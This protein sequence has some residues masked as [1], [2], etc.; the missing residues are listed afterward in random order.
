MIATVP[1]DE[2]QPVLAHNQPDWRRLVEVLT[3]GF[4]GSVMVTLWGWGSPQGGVPTHVRPVGV[5]VAV[6]GIAGLI[7][8]IIAWLRSRKLV[9]RRVL[10]LVVW[11]LPLLFSPPLLSQDGWA[12]AAQGL[13]LIHI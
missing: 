11:S 10:T 2:P 3:M 6:S 13:S 9:G 5:A 4:V 12:Y 8:I 7:A 1:P